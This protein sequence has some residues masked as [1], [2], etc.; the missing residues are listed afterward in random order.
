MYSM[1]F[2]IRIGNYLLTSLESVSVKASV[3]NLADTATIT[4]PGT[5]YNK[6]LEIESKISEGDPVIIQ[7]GYD[8]NLQQLPEEFTGYVE[9]ISTDDG[10]IKI[11]CEDELYK[12]RKDLA[13]ASFQNIKVR[14]LLLYVLKELGGDNTLSCDYEFKY[15]SFTIYQATGFDVLKK[16][17]EDTK[18][19][20]YLKGK[21]LHIHP[22][23]SEIGKKII[24]D[25]GVNVEKSDLKYKDAKKCNVLVTIE[26]TDAKG[27]VVK[28]TKGTPGGDKITIKIPGVSDI[29]T[30]GNRGEEEMKL[31]AYS[32][33][34][35]SLTGWLIPKPEPTD[36]AV[37]R[38]SDYEYKE[39]E[40]Y[41]V[42][43]E[44]TF[45]SSGGERKVTIGKKVG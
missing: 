30:L 35:G 40:Y 33:Y 29:N 27:K 38:D 21:T 20:I 22:Q 1:D 5:A 19:N 18:A 4:L 14:D 7:F 15:D 45:S 41:I 28:E 37:I 13:D 10:S 31:R 32:G 36:I 6:A 39:G 44:S 26:G 8:A 25:F 34:E 23:Y 2:K 9:S 17:Q 42:S 11:S 43:V 3:E 24:Y 16:V 12:F